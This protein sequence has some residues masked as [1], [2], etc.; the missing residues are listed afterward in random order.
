MS[1]PGQNES[2]FPQ[3]AVCACAFFC[4]NTEEKRCEM[5]GVDCARR[6]MVGGG[7][8]ALN[9]SPLP[10]LPNPRPLRATPKVGLS[11]LISSVAS[12]NRRRTTLGENK[13]MLHLIVMCDGSVLHPPPS[14]D[15]AAW[16][17][18][19]RCEVAPV[20]EAA[21]NDPNVLLIRIKGPNDQYYTG[22]AVD[23]GPT[24]HQVAQERR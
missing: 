8:H 15:P 18:V 21:M 24:A 13:K 7:F 16:Q 2:G 22:Y 1:G 23:A 17:Q 6:Y 10:T 4:L 5:D 3:L 11:L 12:A 19:Y 20:I 14:T 9:R